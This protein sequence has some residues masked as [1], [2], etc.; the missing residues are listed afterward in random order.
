MYKRRWDVHGIP[1]YLSAE[2]KMDSESWEFPAAFWLCLF[3]F[4]AAR[5]TILG[6][7]TV[8]CTTKYG[9]RV[10]KSRNV[11]EYPERQ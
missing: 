1:D 6:I 11:H 9:P 4:P 3:D 5:I 8:S 7:F 2:L 10:S